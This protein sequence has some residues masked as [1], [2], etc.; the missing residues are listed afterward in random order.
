MTATSGVLYCA[1]EH[2]R[3]S[4]AR[5]NLLF[6]CQ[7]VPPQLDFFTHPWH[8]HAQQNIS[9]LDLKLLRSKKPHSE[10]PSFKKCW[11]RSMISAKKAFPTVM[12]HKAK[13]SYSFASACA[14][15]SASD[16]KNFKP[17]VPSSFVRRTARRW[18][19][20]LLSL[21]GSS[22]A[23][24]N[25]SWSCRDSNPHQ[26]QSHRLTR[27]SAIQPAWCWSRLHPQPLRQSSHTPR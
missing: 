22:T 23:W 14:T 21:R 16:L 27:A 12:P 18:P 7:V 4:T 5:Q 19:R 15:R 3:H 13:P 10:S 8:E 24:R 9:G 26:H 6:S 17:I 25:G 20:A 1:L 11:P 2:R